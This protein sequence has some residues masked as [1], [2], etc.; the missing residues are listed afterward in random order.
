MLQINRMTKL[1]FTEREGTDKK[2]KISGSQLKLKRGLFKL[3][4]P[5]TCQECLVENCYVTLKVD[6][7]VLKLSRHTTLFKTMGLPELYSHYPIE[8]T[9]HF[10]GTIED[11]YICYECAIFLSREEPSYRCKLIEEY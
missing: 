10:E 1:F 8:M 3:K 5:R 4:S 2:V 7:Y 6:D 11:K 9:D